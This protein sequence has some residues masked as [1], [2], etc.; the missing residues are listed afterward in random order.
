M[1]IMRKMVLARNKGIRLIRRQIMIK[2]KE[3]LEKRVQEFFDFLKK[4]KEVEAKLKEANLIPPWLLWTDEIRNLTENFKRLGYMLK[5]MDEIKKQKI[6]KL[7]DEAKNI[8][9]EGEKKFTGLDRKWTKEE[10][11]NMIKYV[12]KLEDINKTLD[13]CKPKEH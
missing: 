9:A 13:Q 11:E 2:T 6:D 4:N 12:K 3:D 8:I 5:Y 7:A 10:E 1:G